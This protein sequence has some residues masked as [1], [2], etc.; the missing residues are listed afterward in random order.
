MHKIR[1]AIPAI[2]LGLAI[3]STGTVWA[4]PGT[5]RLV[6]ERVRTHDSKHSPSND[7]RPRVRA[8]HQGL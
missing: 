1:V 2:V 4:A 8:V 6:L 3:G 5:G 7:H